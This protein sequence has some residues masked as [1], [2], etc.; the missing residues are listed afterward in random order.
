MIN[1]SNNKI[2]WQLNKH[3]FYNNSFDC[4]ILSILVSFILPLI[5]YIAIQYGKYP[6]EVI[7]NEPVNTCSCFKC[8]Y[9]LTPNNGYNP[10]HDNI[11]TNDIDRKTFDSH[12][13]MGQP[14]LSSIIDNNNKIEILEGYEDEISRT[15]NDTRN[16]D[17]KY[18]NIRKDLDYKKA[19]WFGILFVFSTIFQVY[20]GLKCISF[21]YTNETKEGIFMGVGVLWI[22][23]IV[24]TLRE[25]GIYIYIYIIS[26][27]I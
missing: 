15:N 3:F 23:M 6:I 4:F 24:W 18:L 8:C 16:V 10:L 2:Q 7:E 14:L 5:A 9:N 13:E 1:F 19:V 17:E 20:L 27:I 22:N 11:D 12:N 21:N 25:L 26:I